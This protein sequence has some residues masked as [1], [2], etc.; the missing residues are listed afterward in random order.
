MCVASFLNCAASSRC[1]C[2]VVLVLV[3][4]CMVFEKF[5]VSSSVASDVWLGLF[6]DASDAPKSPSWCGHRGCGVV[7]VSAKV[8]ICFRMIVSLR[9]SAA[10]D[11][12][13]IPVCDSLSSVSVARV[14]NSRVEV[15]LK[16]T[17]GPFPVEPSLPFFHMESVSVNIGVGISVFGVM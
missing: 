10:S 5:S 7:P 3:L 17:L 14:L 2:V 6:F 12:S 16:L 1:L 15:G 9:R 4:L 11:I 13:I 8:S